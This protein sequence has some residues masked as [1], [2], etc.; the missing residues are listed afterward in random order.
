MR[1][2]M[3]NGTLHH[4]ASCL[5][6]PAPNFGRMQPLMESIKVITVS[7]INTCDLLHRTLAEHD[8]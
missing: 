8:A 5:H 2:M 6:E 4:P 1:V 3:R 7:Q